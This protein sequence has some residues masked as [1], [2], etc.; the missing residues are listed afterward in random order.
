MATTPLV[1]DGSKAEKPKKAKKKD[2]KQDLDDLKKELEIVRT[3]MQCFDRVVNSCHPLK[4]V[5]FFRIGTQSHWKRS[6]LVWRRM[7]TRF[8][9][10]CPLFCCYGI[11]V[12]LEEHRLSF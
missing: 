8:V 12:V 10:F 9:K 3:D 7:S 4:I 1:G 2:K 11:A 5:Y 6:V